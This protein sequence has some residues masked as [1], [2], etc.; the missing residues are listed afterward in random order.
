MLYSLKE[1]NEE[2]ETM[3]FSGVCIFSLLKVLDEKGIVK[4]EEVRKEIENSGQNFK[5]MSSLI[6]KLQG[7]E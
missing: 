3:Q 4:V 7:R 5:K 6:K 1:L 2:L